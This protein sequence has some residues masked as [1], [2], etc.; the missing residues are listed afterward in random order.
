MTIYISVQLP[1]SSMWSSGIWIKIINLHYF[2][3]W[4]MYTCQSCFSHS[5]IIWMKYLLFAW[6]FPL[7]SHSTNALLCCTEPQARFCGFVVLMHQK[8]NSAKLSSSSTTLQTQ[9]FFS[10]FLTIQLNDTL[11]MLTV[12]QLCHIPSVGSN[13]SWIYFPLRFQQ[14]TNWPCCWKRNMGHLVSAE[15]LIHTKTRH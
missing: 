6:M 12:R 2:I 8:A 11:K 14:G 13:G 9:E 4:Y 7:K 15:L 5:L 10:L 1:N 3:P